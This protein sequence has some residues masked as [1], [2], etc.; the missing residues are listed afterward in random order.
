VKWIRKAISQDCWSLTRIEFDR[1]NC[2]LKEV[3]SLVFRNCRQFFF[4]NHQHTVEKVERSNRSLP[5]DIVS[6]YHIFIQ[7]KRPQKQ[8][9]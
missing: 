9:K 7:K 4:L 1:E 2:H 6:P 5:S 8:K 3:L